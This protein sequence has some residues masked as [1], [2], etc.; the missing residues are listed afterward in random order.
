MKKETGISIANL[1]SNILNPFL[2]ALVIIVMLAFEARPNPASALRWALVLAVISLAPVL[3]IAAY[4]VRKGKLDSLMSS[5]R[6]QRTEI[7]L[8]AGAVIAV[9]YIILR[10]I[11]APQLLIAALGTGMIMILLFM[12]INFWWKISVH[13]AVV[14]GL[15]TVMVLIYGWLAM[16][17]VIL[18]FLMGWARVILKEHTLA[19]VITGALLSAAVVVIS[20]RIFGIS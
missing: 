18:V 10:L 2:L 8:L 16:L 15:V 19:Q 9:D 14:T 13:A 3:L 4:F 11:S 5:I 1:T 12:C 20:F 17:S 7:Y 6:Q